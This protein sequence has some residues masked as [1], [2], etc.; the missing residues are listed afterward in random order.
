WMCTLVSKKAI[1]DIAR[2]RRPGGLPQHGVRA[3]PLLFFGQQRVDE[4]RLRGDPAGTHEFA[5]AGFRNA[6]RDGAG[7]SH[8]RPPCMTILQGSHTAGDG[9]RHAARARPLV[10]RR[11]HSRRAGGALAPIKIAGPDTLGEPAVAHRL[12]V[13]SGPLSTSLP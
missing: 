2:A 1:I 4:L 11:D 3:Q 8:A 9:T 10:S 7:G 12:S 5:Q 6:Y 13:T